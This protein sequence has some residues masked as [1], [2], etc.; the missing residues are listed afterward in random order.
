MKLKDPIPIER[1]D[2]LAVR[3]PQLRSGRGGRSPD[4]RC[5]SCLLV[6]KTSFLGFEYPAHRRRRLLKSGPVFYQE[7][8]LIDY[9]RLD[10]E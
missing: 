8:I 7:S 3:S 10:S 4:V 5:G 1:I 9:R 2:V 6:F